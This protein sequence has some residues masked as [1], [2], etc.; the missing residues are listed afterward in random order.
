MSENVTNCKDHCYRLLTIERTSHSLYSLTSWPQLANEELLGLAVGGEVAGCGR[1][2]HASS[3]ILLLLNVHEFEL[4][5]CASGESEGLRLC[6]RRNCLS[7]D[8]VG[9]EEFGRF[10]GTGCSDGGEVDSMMSEWID[11]K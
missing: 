10:V 11:A 6:D 4:R 5:D 8:K 9:S 3:A 2:I 7:L 1:L